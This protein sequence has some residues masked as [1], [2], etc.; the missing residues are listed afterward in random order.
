MSKHIKLI[1]LNTV[2]YGQALALQLA[3]RQALYDGTDADDP[4]GYLVCLEHPPTVTLGRR[5]QV[6]DVVG[7][8]LMAAQ[9]IPLFKIDRGGEATAHEPGQLVIY[10][11]L[12]LER[13]G[14]GVVDVIRGMADCLGHAV[15]PFG[16]ETMYNKEAPGVW[17]VH[18]EEDTP[19]VKIASVGMRVAK[20]VSTHGAA[21][22]LTNDMMTTFRMIVPCGMP[23]APMSSVRALTA[24]DLKAGVSRE[25]VQARFLAQFEVFL[26]ATFEP[27]EPLLPDVSLWPEPMINE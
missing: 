27:Y 14:K 9:G 26:G 25:V 21:I 16:L 5:G 23:D 1:S 10:P 24:P 13:L 12:I 19:H 18:P 15:A 2:P 3:L 7:R 22:N 6:T 11:I 17:T 20:G 8:Q 4:A